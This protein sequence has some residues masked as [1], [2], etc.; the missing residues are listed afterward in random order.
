VTTS[1]ADHPRHSS[2]CLKPSAR[3]RHHG[4]LAGV[5]GLPA[6]PDELFDPSSR[7]LRLVF[8]GQS[9]FP[10]GTFATTAWLDVRFV[11]LLARD[12]ESACRKVFI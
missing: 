3:H 10:V 7:L 5:E 1:P 6:R 8:A 9:S 2:S 12:S 4:I 11:S